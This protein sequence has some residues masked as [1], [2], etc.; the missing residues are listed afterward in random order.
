MR[1]DLNA[2]SDKNAERRKEERSKQAIEKRAATQRRREAL[3]RAS[4]AR[5]GYYP[6]PS[7]KQEFLAWPQEGPWQVQVLGDAASP[8]LATRGY[9]GADS[10][11]EAAIRRLAQETGLDIR[12]SSKLER[13]EAWKS[14]NGN[15]VRVLLTET[16]RNKAP[17][18]AF[19]VYAKPKGSTAS[20]IRVMEV[21]VATYRKWGGVAAMLHSRGIIPSAEVF[22]A[23]QRERIASAPLRKQMKLYEAILDR[24]YVEQSLALMMTQAQVTAM[25][26]ELNYDLL[27]GNDITP[28]G[29]WGD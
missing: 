19:V 27:F 5:K 22:P 13:L 20:S 24:F 7:N 16:R 4:G 3:Y 6:A 29:L 18:V 14:F 26:T 21:P 15:D 2:L 1:G 17:A 8:R 28:G 10:A 9:D 11:P 23:D 25:M 12:G